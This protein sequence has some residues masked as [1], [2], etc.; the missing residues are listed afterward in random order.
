[1]LTI[2]LSGRSLLVSQ[3]IS[4]IAFAKTMHAPLAVWA[5]ASETLERSQSLESPSDSL[6]QS[7]LISFHHRDGSR[8][9]AE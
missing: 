3:V 1:M 6:L 8:V 5:C 2:A 7:L 4:P 9:W